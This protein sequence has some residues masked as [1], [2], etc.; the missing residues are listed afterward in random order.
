MM[1]L[2]GNLGAKRNLYFYFLPLLHRPKKCSRATATVSGRF[3]K[4]NLGQWRGSAFLFRGAQNIKHKF[5]FDKKLPSYQ[6]SAQREMFN[7]GGIL[8]ISRHGM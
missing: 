4:Q 6:A 3:S 7:K 8:Y 5:R 2:L 1:Q